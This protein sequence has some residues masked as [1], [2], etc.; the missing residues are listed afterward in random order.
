[1]FKKHFHIIYFLCYFSAPKISDVFM[2]L[3]ATAEPFMHGRAHRGMVIGARNILEKVHTQLKEA[4]ERNPSYGILVTG[5]S[6][7]AGTE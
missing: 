4:I 2:D 7:G 3:C 1:M 5:Y 6:L